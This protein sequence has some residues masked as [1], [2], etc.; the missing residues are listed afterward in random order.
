MSGSRQKVVKQTSGSCQA[1]VKKSSGSYKVVLKT[2]N[3]LVV[4]SNHAY[5]GNKLLLFIPTLF[6]FPTL[7]KTNILFLKVMTFTQT[8]TMIA[9]FSQSDFDL[10]FQI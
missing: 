3:S 8:K 7:E 5:L 2:E 4:F 10:K 9:T 1:V 6:S